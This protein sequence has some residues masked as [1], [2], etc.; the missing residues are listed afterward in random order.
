M[1][2]IIEKKSEREKSKKSNYQNM[3]QIVDIAKYAKDHNISYGKAQA[4]IYCSAT[5]IVRKW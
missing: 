2:S 3:K 1:A 4:E 5:K